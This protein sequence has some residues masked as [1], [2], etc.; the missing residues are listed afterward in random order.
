MALNPYGAE[1]NQQIFDSCVRSVLAHCGVPLIDQPIEGLLESIKDGEGSVDTA[2][3][4][5]VVGHIAH[6]FLEV[7]VPF[8][9]PEWT[10]ALKRL[11]PRIESGL[12]LSREVLVKSLPSSARNGGDVDRVWFAVIPRE[13]GM[14]PWT[15][16]GDS[17]LLQCDMFG[18]C[19]VR[20]ALLFQLKQQGPIDLNTLAREFGSS[21]SRADSFVERSTAWHRF[22][23]ADAIR[24]FLEDPKRLEWGEWCGL[25]DIC[26]ELMQ[27]AEP[28]TESPMES[29]DDE[30]TP[31]S[32]LRVSPTSAE[33]WA[34][35]FGRVAAMWPLVDKPNSDS[36][37]SEYFYDWPNGLAAL[38][39][40]LGARV[41]D[42]ELVDRC[43]TGTA[44]ASTLKSESGWHSAYPDDQSASNPLFWLM[45]LGFLHGSRRVESSG[46]ALPAR[47]VEPS[48]SHALLLGTHAEL[49]RAIEEAR[50]AAEQ[51]KMA[52]I[53]DELVERLSGVWDSL[54]ADSQVHLVDAELH[55]K[56]RRW[57]DSSLDYANAVETA[58]AEWLSAPRDL[59]PRDQNDWPRSIGQ[60]VG[61]LQ[62]MSGTRNARRGL[63][64]YLRR[65]F[66]PRYA[67]EL[68]SSLD[69]LREARQPRAH[70]ERHPPF[71]N[72][73]RHVVLG[74]DQRLGVFELILRF[75]KRWQG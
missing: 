28:T 21:V 9:E 65:R 43:W 3:N 26:A 55:L 14:E 2:L 69:V 53:R 17:A 10:D 42:E 23:V 5:V 58:L 25:V 44:V 40:L 62:R 36:H 54:P 75:A 73:A 11:K 71:A 20:D 57:P 39:L 56:E 29:L 67:S 8:E 30:W 22:V 18:M 64:G 60:W 49:G 16:L 51:E 37:I 66:D 48:E 12:E 4:L 74:E 63:D 41:P 32:E 45:R 38:S 7:H 70:G 61:C 1:T 50:A 34:W 31:T 59:S 19:F 6:L 52:R 27:S 47:S 13:Y 35:E 72:K 33:Y 24:A 15:E 46:P 68:A